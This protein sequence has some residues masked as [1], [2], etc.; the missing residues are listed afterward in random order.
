MTTESL[1]QREDKDL[2]LAIRF[3]RASYGPEEPHK[4]INFS[5]MSHQAFA[6]ACGRLTDNLE[7]DNPY[8]SW[9]K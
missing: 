4:A 5:G 8:R 7:M 2:A 6:W 3:I 1:K 9:E